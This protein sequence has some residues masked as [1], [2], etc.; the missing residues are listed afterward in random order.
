MYSIS[1]IGPYTSRAYSLEHKKF[2]NIVI[3]KEKYIYVSQQVRR[4]FL[5]RVKLLFHRLQIHN[6]FMAFKWVPNVSPFF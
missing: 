2:Y 1:A 5:L 6:L 3:G 4:D